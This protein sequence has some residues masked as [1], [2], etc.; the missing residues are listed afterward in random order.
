MPG[1]FSFL[2]LDFKKVLPEIRHDIIKSTVIAG[3]GAIGVIL[4]KQLPVL[5][6]VLNEPH[7]FPLYG[8]ILLFCGGL[9]IGCWLTSAFL[10]SKL[11]TLNQLADT[12]PL[13]GLGNLRKQTVSLDE[14]MQCAASAGHALSIIYIDI[15]KFKTVNDVAGHDSGDYVLRQFAEILNL[16]RKVSDIVCRCGGDEFLIIAPKTPAPGS[17]IY[18]N[19]LRN[20]VVTTPFKVL[21]QK[22]DVSLTT[23]SGVAEFNPAAK[24]LPES[25]IKRAESAMMKAKARRNCVEVIN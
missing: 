9:L 3:L 4:A 19:R 22:P 16:N 10:R 18:A 24:E 25:F 8:L 1:K 7:N 14:A 13:T 12:D 6:S 2:K 23:S 20:E 21:H 15:D 11:E 17:L 5:G